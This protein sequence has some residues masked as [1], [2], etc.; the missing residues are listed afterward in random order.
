MS[1]LQKK[2]WAVAEC[3]QLTN[4]IEYKVDDFEAFCEPLRGADEA[5]ILTAIERL[6]MA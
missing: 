2:V 5:E 6:T 4:L 1:E 3:Y